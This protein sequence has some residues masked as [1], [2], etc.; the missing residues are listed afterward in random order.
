MKKVMGFAVLA[1][2]AAQVS[3][4]EERKAFDKSQNK[5]GEQKASFE[6]PAFPFEGEVSVERLN[7]RMFPKSD[8]TG[9]IAAIL[10]LGEKVSVV[11]E[12]DDFF[13]ILPT[14]GCTAWIFARSVKREGAGGV[15]TSP[16]AA[17]RTDSRVNA[18]ALATLKEGDAVKILSE[19]MGWYKIE[20]PA[21]VKY[22]VAR[23][24]VRPG[25][26]LDIAVADDK[27]A[28]K[29]PAPRA[30]AEAGTR[31]PAVE[32]LIDEQRK[33][34]DERRLNEVDF[35]AVVNALDQAK[36]NAT[37]PVE[38]ADAERLYKSYR[39]LHLVWTTIKAKA[40]EERINAQKAHEAAG[41]KAP[42]KKEWAMT[43]YVDTTGSTLFK[44]PGSH[45][46]VMGGK[47]VAFLR[48]KDGD[49]V[50]I[51][52]MNDH[53]EKYVGVNGVVIKDPEGWPGYSVIVVEEI[54]PLM[55]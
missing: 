10:G 20:A 42:E 13:Q 3:A 15:V 35:G 26:R 31:L 7:V 41:P 50:T 18:E 45:K 12:R 32:A 8:P 39:D 51:G 48:A 53:Y 33:L 36:E 14:R 25:Q 17:V 52:R 40:E 5:A 55:K 4:Q 44:R 22:F 21:A 11:G 38:K 6:R 30:R 16:E 49:P 43:G 23:K 29:E 34:I 1:I 47:I 54:T 37:N 24:Y 27:G 2:L 9:V 46:L 19:H 28:K